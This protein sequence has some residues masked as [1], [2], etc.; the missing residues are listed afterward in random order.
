MLPHGRCKPDA[1]L[2]EAEVDRQRQRRPYTAGWLPDMAAMPGNSNQSAC[3]QYDYAAAIA[4]SSAPGLP[5]GRLVGA[6]A[7][8]APGPAGNPAGE[9]R[10]ELRPGR[11]R[12]SLGDSFLHT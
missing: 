5:P 10:S 6:P 1:V 12:R 9:V 8:D 7:A 4:S 3:Q 2:A 11:G